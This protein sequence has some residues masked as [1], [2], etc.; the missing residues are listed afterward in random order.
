MNL[1]I[2]EIIQQLETWAPPGL[3]EDYDNSGL[4]C[5]NS[6]EPCTGAMICL[7]STPEV[8]QEAIQKG[9]NLV[10]AHHPIVFSGIK[11]LTGKNYI[12][13]A[14]LL[15]I[16]ND[17]AIYAIHT[18]LDN[19]HTG[20][21]R[22]IGEMLGVSHPS[23]LRSAEGHLL[24]LSVYVPN[25][26]ATSVMEALFSAGAGAIGKYDNCSFTLQ[27]TGTF[28]PG[29]G[30]DPFTGE[31]GVRRY[32]P[33]T[34]IETILPFWKKDAV[35]KALVE[36]HPYEEVAYNFVK[37]ENP[38]QETGS[39]MVGNFDQAVSTVDLLHKIKSIFGGT[40][41]H[42]AL[43]ND[44]ITRIAWCGGSGSFLLK[45]AI[46]SGAQVFLTSDFKYHQFFDADGKI[47]IIDIG[48]F[49]NE[50]FTMQLIYDHLKDNFPNFAPCLTSV[51]TNPIHY[52]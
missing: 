34:R 22:K 37:L 38:L 26:H 41:R 32:E 28:R 27:G 17:I 16:K 6:N 5:G 52:F 7:D 46:S 50:Q 23:I 30:A 19:V 10:I 29:E 47:L 4:I 18:N 14:L 15:A 44:Q 3:Q 39:G 40:I 42:T 8:I 11:K 43:L 51:Q 25:E 9:C 48:H 31:I 33:E 45:D 20:V 2:Q 21:N 24:Q 49:E 12:E 13:R 1:R 36:A 35:F